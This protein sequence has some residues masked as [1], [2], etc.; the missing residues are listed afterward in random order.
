VHEHALQ[1]ADLVPTLLPFQR[2][3]IAWLLVREGKAVGPDGALIPLSP[4]GPSSLP[5][6]WAAL[7]GPAGPLYV[8]RFTG[9][10]LSLPPPPPL[11][12]ACLGGILAKVPGLGKTLESIALILL[13]PAP[14]ARSPAVRHWDA[15]AQL[16][17]REV[18]TTLIVTPPA[19]A[20]QWADKLARHT[21]RLRVLAYDGWARVLVPITDADADAE[22]ARRA[23]KR[24]AGAEDVQDWCTF[25]HKFDVVITTYTVL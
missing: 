5:L 15:T 20:P 9:A 14:A 22:R 24:H 21:P 2:R 19:L 3:S 25:A 7:A 16:D 6:F 1:P 18:R 10:V 8:N 4:P 13:N 12:S 17:V 23:R 11:P